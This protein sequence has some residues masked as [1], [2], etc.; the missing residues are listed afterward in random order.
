MVIF[1]PIMSVSF[2]SDISKL[3]AEIFLI[4]FMTDTDIALKMRLREYSQDLSL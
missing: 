4:N 3:K 1:V 2:Y